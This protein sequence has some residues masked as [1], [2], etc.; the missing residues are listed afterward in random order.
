MY[1]YICICVYIYIFHEPIPVRGQQKLLRVYHHLPQPP[2]RP[3]R[4]LFK[5][6]SFL[7]NVFWWWVNGDLNKKKIGSVVGSVGSKL[8]QLEVIFWIDLSCSIGQTKPTYLSRGALPLGPQLFRSNSAPNLRETPTLASFNDICKASSW[9][10]T[11][12]WGQQ[13]SIG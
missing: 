11:A 9:V 13:L 4:H 8:G 2:C 6:G 5:H 12:G 7:R 3:G 10:R 1:I